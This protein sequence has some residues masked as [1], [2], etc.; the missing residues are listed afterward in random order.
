MSITG[1]IAVW[2]FCAVAVERLVEL[3]VKIIP[4][5]DKKKIANVDLGM[6]LAFTYA[7]VIAIGAKLDFFTIFGIEF[8]IAL[9]GYII[10]A[11]FMAGGTELIHSIINLSESEKQISKATVKQ[12][13]D[14]GN[15]VNSDLE[16]EHAPQRGDTAQQ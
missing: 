6:L 2:L 15:L 12:L 10:A 14:G 13:Q 16:A 7:L 1:M 9:V 8:N 3:T 11:L 5:L 4:W